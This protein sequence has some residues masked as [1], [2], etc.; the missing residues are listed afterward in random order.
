M[1]NFEQQDLQD[2]DDILI[3]DLD[4]PGT[5]REGRGQHALQ[6]LHMPQRV[7][8]WMAGGTL[9]GLAL[10]L[11]LLLRT[12]LPELT[13]KPAQPAAAVA[14][15]YLMIFGVS[16]Q[17][18]YVFNGMDG[19]IGALQSSN[20]AVLWHYLPAAHTQGMTLVNNVI[21]FLAF[22]GKEGSVYA[23][24]ARNGGRIWRTSLQSSYPL[25]LS[26][27]D[28]ALYVTTRD[29]V[30]YA[31]RST[32]G[33]LLWRYHAYQ[34]VEPPNDLFIT[35]VDGIAYF[36]IQLNGDELQARRADDDSFL[37]Q[38]TADQ[39]QDLLAA[40]D[41]RTFVRDED[42]SISA[43]R[44]DN[45]SVLWRYRGLTEGNFAPPIAQD[46]GYFVSPDGEIDALRLSDGAP[47]WHYKKDVPL[48][49]TLTL[50]G[51]ELYANTV[52]GTI[53]AFDAR[54]GSLHWKY[55]IGN[56]LS[57]IAVVNGQVYL[58]ASDGNIYDL[59]A[60]ALLWRYYVGQF[61][62][63]RDVGPQLQVIG[64]TVYMTGYNNTLYALEANNGTLLW[65]HNDIDDFP[66]FA[67]GSIY[68]SIRGTALD[69][70]EASTGKTRWRVS[71]QQI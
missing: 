31:L 70:I 55:T 34:G 68:V 30:V 58:G 11:F 5:R 69:A 71:F 41:G 37:W 40:I 53:Y 57:Q 18:I 62:C 16:G 46:T 47:L 36:D 14:N 4:L 6:S 33:S 50:V 10:L 1:N 7:R 39:K 19:G 35:A 44:S 42:G 9:L 26:V 29:G 66:V 17:R 56:A 3:E 13:A 25:W 49:G 32:D 60:G 23:L 51:N 2:D 67:D 12:A 43:L 38:R 63:C 59:H 8:W 64:R 21:Y 65:R 20:G 52:D 54:T 45:G 48:L 61:A 27:I 15:P 24:N 28:G 22:D